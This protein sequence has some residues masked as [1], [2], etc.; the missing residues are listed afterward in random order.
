M[1]QEIG[2]IKVDSYIIENCFVCEE[3][4]ECFKIGDRVTVDDLK[5]YH[6]H[7]YLIRGDG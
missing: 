6:S 5:H 3:C 1:I 2:P 7:C 4:L